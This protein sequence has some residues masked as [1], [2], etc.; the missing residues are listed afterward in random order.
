MHFRRNHQGDFIWLAIFSNGHKIAF[1]IK[2]VKGCF[3]QRHK[4]CQFRMYFIFI[5]LNISC[6]KNTSD[7]GTN[8]KI[9]KYHRFFGISPFTNFVW[10]FYGNCTR[11]YNFKFCSDIA[12]KIG[13]I[14]LEYLSLIVIIWM[15]LISF[16]H[17]PLTW[18]TNKR[19]V[20]SHA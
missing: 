3:S 2:F 20:H 12:S 10:L 15:R 13:C 7:F 5:Y 19:Y 8:P 1:L 6:I 9:I 18:W 14:V 17:I 11:N 4:F 16:F